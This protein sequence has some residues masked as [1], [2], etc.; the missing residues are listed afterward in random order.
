MTEL[1]ALLELAP[2]QQVLAPSLAETHA[3]REAVADAIDALPEDDQWIF[4]V[5]YVAGLSLRFTGRVLGI[6]KTT[7]ARRRDTIRLHLLDTL[8]NHPEVKKWLD[9]RPPPNT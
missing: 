2:G 5:L 4:N 8:K 9:T 3:L 7:L 1:E 6:P